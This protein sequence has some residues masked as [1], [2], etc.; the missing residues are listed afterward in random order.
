M[1]PPVILS[2]AGSDPSGGAGIQ[3]DIK[4]ISAL[5]GYAAAAITALTVQNTLGVQAVT[6][7][8]ASVV[9]AQVQAVLTDLRP[10]AIKIGMTGSA[11]VVRTLA[12]LLQGY[13]SVPV[14]LDPVMASTS[15]HRLMDAEALEALRRQLFPCC[16]LVTPNLPEVQLLLERPIAT[17]DE[18]KQAALTL[19]HTYGTAFLVK[20]GHLEGGAMCDVLYDGAQHHLFTAPRI[21]SPNLHGTGCTLSSALATCLAQGD[22]LPQ[23]VSR[24]KRYISQAIEAAGRL[25]IGQGNGPLWHFVHPFP[26]S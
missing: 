1:R 11:A 24:A 2:I 20:G 6:P 25:H 10:Q 4:T 9:G 3:A 26:Q 15:G 19:S 14:V 5:G 18:M 23:A 13:P 16:T 12:D 21:D 17:I 7:V 8:E 22:T